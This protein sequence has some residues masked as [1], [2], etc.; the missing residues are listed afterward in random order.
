M[1]IHGT[2]ALV[3]ERATLVGQRLSTAGWHTECTAGW[4]TVSVFVSVLPCAGS[5]APKSRAAQGAK[6]HDQRDRHLQS[7]LVQGSLVLRQT[8]S[9]CGA[10]L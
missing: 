2:Q 10:A 8:G 9:F 7:D 3:V 4:R 1:A 5:A 6:Q